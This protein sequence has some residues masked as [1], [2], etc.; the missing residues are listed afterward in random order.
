[1][2]R[3]PLAVAQGH[4]GRFMPSP[5]MRDAS[6][7]PALIL[8]A[9]LGTRLAPLTSRRAKPSLP[10]AGQ[11]LIA[12]ILDHLQDAGIRRVVINL[13]AHADSIT[14]IVGDGR[15][16][17]LDVSYSWEPAILG[18]GG[19]P[20]RALPLLAHDRFFIVNGDTLTDIDLHA[21]AATHLQSGAEA[22][23]AVTVGDTLRYN[24]LA[25]SEDGALERRVLRGTPVPSSRPLWHFTG[26]QAVNASIF[27]GVSAS[28]AS[29]VLTD[30]YLP[31]AHQR[32]GHIR[33][34]PT[35]ASFLDIGTPADY[36]ETSLALAGP[37]RVVCGD[38]CHIDPTASVTDCVLWDDVEVGA[39][40]VL[41]H[42]IVTSGVKVA[43]GMR[44][45][46]RILTPDGVVPC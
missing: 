20:A 34:W 22:T 45:D 39:G 29:E 28:Q 27:S 42:C 26:V 3:G 4:P 2:G 18:S 15:P 13:H 5:C 12:R 10:V 31:R 37:A 25:A 7:W 36:L 40:T 1:M 43:P 44:Y 21:L 11:P 30:L 24:A 35:R 46:R 6:S 32:H 17:N 23:L 16:W 9:G 41:S 33:L 8:A 38:R 14:A 19:G